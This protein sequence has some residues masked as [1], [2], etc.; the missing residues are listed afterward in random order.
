MLADSAAD[1][2]EALRES[3]RGVV[4]VQ[5]RRRPDSGAQGRRRRPRVFAKPAR[6]HGRQC[7]KSWRWSRRLPIRELSLDGEAIVTAAGRL[8][9]TV[10]DHDAAVRAPAR[11]REPAANRCRSPRCSS[12]CCTCDGEPLVDEPLTRRVSRARR[13]RGSGPTS[14]LASSPPSQSEAA[15]FAE[16]ALAAGHEGVMAKALDGWLR[17][18][19]PRVSVAQGQA[20]AHARSR[21]PGRGVGQRPPARDAEQPAPRRARCRTRRLRHAG[22]DVQRPDRRDARV[23]DEAVPRASRSARDATP[24]T[25]GPRWSSRSR[26][27]T[28]RR[29]RSIPAV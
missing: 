6:C 12:T 29:A 23:A 22:Q 10:P 2:T 28:C 5:A 19:P 11:R 13:D 9:P 16:R 18:R 21:R 24:S 1:V 3:G 20:G 27:T 25:S 26:S 7:R 4:R 17:R 15:A 14:C 8:S